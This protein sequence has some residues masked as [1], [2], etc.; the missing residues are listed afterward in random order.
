MTASWLA[1]MGWEVYVVDAPAT[2]FN[3]AGPGPP[4]P[5]RPRRRRAILIGVAELAAR[6]DRDVVTVLDARSQPGATAA[7][8]FQARGS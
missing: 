7:A 6:L 1:Q 5:A 2:R 8:T 4:R 3:A